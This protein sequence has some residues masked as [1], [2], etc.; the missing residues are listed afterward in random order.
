M[1]Q[2]S[3]VCAPRGRTGPAALPL[4][5]VNSRQG[6]QTGRGPKIGRI[7]TPKCC[8]NVASYFLCV[9][10]PFLYSG[11]PLSNRGE[12]LMKRRWL[13]LLSVLMLA[14]LV[15]L[16]GAAMLSG[17][18][19]TQRVNEIRPGIEGSA[20][21]LATRIVAPGGEATVT[22]Q[23][24]ATQTHSAELAATLRARQ[25]QVEQAI[26]ATQTAKARLVLTGT[27]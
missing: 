19:L 20:T 25:D 6:G 16:I 9:D 23:A 11:E 24:G 12:I 26:Q 21:A 7:F 27:P 3:I 8:Q 15:L 22:S 10:V 1:L 17:A 13:I 18:A 2:R 14:C 5:A 4:G